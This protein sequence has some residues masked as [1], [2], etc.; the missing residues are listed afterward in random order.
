MPLGWAKLGPIK[1]ASRIDVPSPASTVQAGTVAV[2]GVA[3]A[4]DRGISKVELQVDNGE[5]QPA[6]L[7]TP[8]SKT[9][10]VQWLVRWQAVSGN[11]Q[12]RVRATDGAGALQ[13]EEPHDPA[14][15]G[16]TGYHTIP[17]TVS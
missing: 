17:V 4:P 11:H 9:T 14:P 8:I 1:T 5:W 3:W 2:A 7:S 16:A 12:L 13:V 6:Q 10:W 15:N